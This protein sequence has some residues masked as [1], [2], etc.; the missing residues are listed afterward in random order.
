M[1][2]WRRKRRTLAYTLPQTELDENIR[3]VLIHL[4]KHLGAITIPLGKLPTD[5]YVCWDKAQRPDGSTEI[6]VWWAENE[7]RKAG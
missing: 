3:N 4:V 1:K 7:E 5:G 2:F 6:T